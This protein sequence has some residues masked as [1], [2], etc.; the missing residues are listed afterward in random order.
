MQAHGVF[1]RVLPPL[2]E[3]PHFD[4]RSYFLMRI[5][6]LGLISATCLG[7]GYWEDA[8]M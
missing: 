7:K 4:E 5:D 1:K 8:P 6:V 2:L 3:L